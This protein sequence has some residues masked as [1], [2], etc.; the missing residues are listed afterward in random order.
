MAAQFQAG[1][2]L[3]DPSAPRFTVQMLARAGYLPAGTAALGP[4]PRLG[5]ARQVAPEGKA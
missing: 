4:A 5:L 3:L 2:R 1:H